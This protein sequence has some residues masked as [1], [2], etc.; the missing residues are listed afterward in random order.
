MHMSQLSFN[1][2]YVH[3]NYC[4]K[5]GNIEKKN[6]GLENY[7]Q[8]LLIHRKRGLTT[9]LNYVHNYLEPKPNYKL[10]KLIKFHTTSTNWRLCHQPEV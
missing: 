9:Y 2:Q 3:I 10:T 4:N 7:N 8:V 1:L 5:T 6:S